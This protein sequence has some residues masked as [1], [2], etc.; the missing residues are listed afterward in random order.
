MTK[1]LHE[2]LQAHFGIKTSYRLNP[3]VA[4]VEITVTKIVS[5]NPNRLNLLIVNTGTANIHLSPVNTVT[6]GTGTILVPA[7]GTAVFV[8]DEDFELVGNEFFGIADGAASTI[9]VLEVYTQ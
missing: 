5:Y 6:V 7:G 3:E 9:Y 8:W 4:Q 2:L 1:T